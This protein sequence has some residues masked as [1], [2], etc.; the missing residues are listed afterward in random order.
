MAER[1]G[2]DVLPVPPAEKEC[3]CDARASERRER[4]GG[5]DV[6]GTSAVPALSER[7]RSRLL[8]AVREKLPKDKNRPRQRA[9]GGFR[10]LYRFPPFLGDAIFWREIS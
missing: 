7:A 8:P 9:R 1:T 4:R 3:R 5:F 2:R 10:A 6:T